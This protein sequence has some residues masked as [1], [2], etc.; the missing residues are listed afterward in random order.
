MERQINLS[1]TETEVIIQALHHLKE[2]LRD[3]T[4]LDDD[5]LNS[6]GSVYRKLTN[7]AT[8]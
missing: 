5:K 8:V 1:E 2:T 6:L 3:M 7:A 4:D